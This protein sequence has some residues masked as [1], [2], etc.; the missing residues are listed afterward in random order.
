MDNSQQNSSVNVDRVCELLMSMDW[1]QVK[2]WS[3]AHTITLLSIHLGKLPN[4][5]IISCLSRIPSRL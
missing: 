2:D 5:C 4:A 1:T 3:I